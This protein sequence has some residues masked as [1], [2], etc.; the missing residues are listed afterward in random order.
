MTYEEWEEDVHE[1]VRAEP[2]WQ[3]LG[4]RKALFFY[5]LVWQ[6]SEKLVSDRRGRAIAEQLVRSAGSVSANV[7]EGH[8]R[9]YG[10]QRNWFFT[11]SIGSARESKGW[12]WRAR[13]LV[14]SE[15]L[16]HRLALADEV[17]A[18]LVTELRRQKSR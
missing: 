7:E 1:R 13:H 12:Y 17:I 5:E 3:F 18:L 2:I 4:Y 16:D 10:K 8:G 15:V 14:S 6:D 11:V 9:G